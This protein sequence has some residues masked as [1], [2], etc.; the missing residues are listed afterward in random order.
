MLDA[1]TKMRLEALQK[2]TLT[3]RATVEPVSYDGSASSCTHKHLFSNLDN[4]EMDFLILYTECRERREK[5][6]KQLD[7]ERLF[8]EKHPWTSRST[9]TIACT[10]CRLKEIILM[11]V[12]WSLTFSDLHSRNERDRFN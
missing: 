2:S 6:S 8:L 9:I 11:H 7:E 1:G 5:K 4:E 12:N 10:L 3:Q